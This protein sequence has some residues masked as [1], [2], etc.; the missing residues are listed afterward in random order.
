MIAHVA[1]AAAAAASPGGPPRRRSRWWVPLALAAAAL[2]CAPVA[3]AA[4][5]AAGELELRGVYVYNFI[6]FT[7]WPT[8]TFTTSTTPLTVAVFGDP[9]LAA[10]LQRLLAGKTL[11]S[12][13]IAVSV[14]TEPA[15]CAT[16]QA[17]FV[18]NARQKDLGAVLTAVGERPVLTISDAP[19]FV[20]QGG[21][22]R[23]FAADRRLRFEVNT[24]ATGG[25]RLTISSRLLQLAESVVRP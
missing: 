22:I 6:R 21:M 5:R 8:G 1:P 2:A 24:R 7:E 18:G 16:A 23:I 20:R 13:P 15:A 25:S 3:R 11:D 14:A 19:S 9:E 17:V 4:D 10:T 12:H